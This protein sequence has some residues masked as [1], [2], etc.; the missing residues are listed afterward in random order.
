[1]K[2]WEEVGVDRVNFILNCLEEIPQ[3]QVLKSLRLFAAEVMPHFPRDEQPGERLAAVGS[4][5]K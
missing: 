5:A 2:K 1:M 4:A 3:E